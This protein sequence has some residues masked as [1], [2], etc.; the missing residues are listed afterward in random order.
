MAANL[1]VETRIGCKFFGMPGE[2]GIE[3]YMC[4]ETKQVGVNLVSMWG[5][6][7]HMN[8][9]IAQTVMGKV[10][11][12]YN[13]NVKVGVGWAHKFASKFDQRPISFRILKRT[14][15]DGTKE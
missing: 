2:G 4:K 5:N 14:H 10:S 7:L 13:S 15:P 9:A 12:M 11:E 8:A 3:A 1:S 6:K